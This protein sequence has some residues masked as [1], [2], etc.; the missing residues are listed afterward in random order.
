MKCASLQACKHLQGTVRKLCKTPPA[1]YPARQSY[2]SW[3]GG[4]IVPYDTVRDLNS[5]Q[6]EFPARKVTI[7]SYSLYADW[8]YLILIRV[9][10]ENNDTVTTDRGKW[11]KKIMCNAFVAVDNTRHMSAVSHD[12]ICTFLFRN[13]LLLITITLSE[14]YDRA[15]VHL[16]VKLFMLHIIPYF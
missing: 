14:V 9:E 7:F 15:S 12:S 1:V 10:K 6:D 3:E 11:K 2:S 8:W 16:L 13:R 5:K 4:C